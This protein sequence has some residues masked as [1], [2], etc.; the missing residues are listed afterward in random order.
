MNRRHLSIV[1]LSQ[2]RHHNCPSGLVGSGGTSMSNVPRFAERFGAQTVGLLV[3]DELV[4]DGIVMNLA[5]EKEG[6]VGR[7]TGDVRMAGRVDIGARLT[8]RPDA[9]K[10]VADVEVSRIAGDLGLLADEQGVRAGDYFAVITGFNPAGVA[11]KA[12]GA[13]AQREP[14][15]VAH[16]EL[17]AIGVASV[18]LVALRLV[19]DWRGGVGIVGPLAE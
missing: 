18:R 10:E 15:V 7:V 17:H 2:S 19:L 3:A 8:P 11:F 4:L 12:D 6:D 9:V 14:A 13:G 16:D 5:T 1:E